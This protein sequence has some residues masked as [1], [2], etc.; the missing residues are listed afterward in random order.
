MATSTTPSKMSAID[1]VTLFAS[2][3]ENGSS[4]IGSYGVSTDRR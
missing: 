2:R 1:S 3:Q 4:P